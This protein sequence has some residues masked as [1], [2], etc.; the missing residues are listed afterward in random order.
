VQE[1]PCLWY[2]AWRMMTR[3]R[4]VHSP[5]LIGLVS[6]FLGVLLAMPSTASAQPTLAIE[7]RDACAS[8][9]VDRGVA[10]MEFRFE[11]TNDPTHVF[12][13]GVCYEKNSRTPAAIQ[14]FER[15]VALPNVSAAARTQAQARIARLRNPAA[16]PP[17]AAAPRAPAPAPSAPAQ[18]IAIVGQAQRPAGTIVMPR[19]QPPR[20]VSSALDPVAPVAAPV[21]T[22]T[23]EQSPTPRDAPEYVDDS[24]NREP[25]EYWN[26]ARVGA[27]LAGGIAAAGLGYAWYHTDD[28]PKDRHAAQNKQV[29]GLV[30][31]GTAL[32]TAVVLLLVADDAPAPRKAKTTRPIVP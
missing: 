29:A 1:T 6:I 12:N 30:I 26:G 23:R 3:S 22:Y 19:A 32:V 16:A 9:Q 24:P 8:G 10:L 11:Q 13:Q 31:G 4:N 25:P 7:A 2:G 21:P 5:A 15:F 17:P 27:V 18:P 28:N 20:I 14:T